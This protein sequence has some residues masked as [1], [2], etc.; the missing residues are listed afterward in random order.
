MK[1]FT[2][3]V[4]C[5]L[6]LYPIVVSTLTISRDLGCTKVYP[7]WDA[8]KNIRAMGID[9]FTENSIGGGRVVAVTP[10]SWLKAKIMGTAYWD[11]TYGVQQEAA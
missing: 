3:E 9:V 8:I 11:R 7:V 5:S 6:P 1:D 10:E 4:L 2:M